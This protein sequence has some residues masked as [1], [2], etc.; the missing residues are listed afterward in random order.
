MVPEASIM[1]TPGI[2]RGE[3]MLPDDTAAGEQLKAG[4]TAET[5]HHSGIYIC[6]LR[7]HPHT[8]MR[9]HAR[10]REVGLKHS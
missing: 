6:S 1:K 4:G 10:A 9:A 5:V 3:V 7:T 8:H 2:H